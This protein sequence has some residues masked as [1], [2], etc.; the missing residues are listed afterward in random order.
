MTITFY[1]IPY[2][3]LALYRVMKLIL[4]FIMCYVIT[5]SR[6]NEND[7]LKASFT[8][9]KKKLFGLPIG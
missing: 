2:I 5:C 8:N 3:I 6:L 4:S 9:V 7:C 1:D